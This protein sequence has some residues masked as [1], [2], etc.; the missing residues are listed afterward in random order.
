MYHRPMSRQVWVEAQG[1]VQPIPGCEPLSPFLAARPFNYNDR[2]RH[3]RAVV[4]WMTGLPEVAGDIRCWF[5]TG[6]GT[7]L[8]WEEVP[9]NM[10]IGDCAANP[11]P[12]DQ[13]SW[14]VPGDDGDRRL[15]AFIL[16]WHRR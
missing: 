7:N 3:V 9:A 13:G 2:I 16:C 1:W 10:F 12:E 8:E 14:G 15:T 4:A 5:M 11:D 6:D